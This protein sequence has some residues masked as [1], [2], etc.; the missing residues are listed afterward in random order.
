MQGSVSI[1]CSGSVYG[2]TIWHSV[3]WFVDESVGWLRDESRGFVHVSSLMSS[4]KLWLL[5]T[6]IIEGGGGGLWYLLVWMSLDTA[7]KGNLLSV[8]LDTLCAL[9]VLWGCII[10]VCS[11]PEYSALMSSCNL[12]YSAQ[13]YSLSLSVIVDCSEYELCPSWHSS[14]YRQGVS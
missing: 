4:A 5:G 7:S 1:W 6:E 11:Q 9:F 13:E 8:Y 12:L 2:R 14:E 10:P 3:L